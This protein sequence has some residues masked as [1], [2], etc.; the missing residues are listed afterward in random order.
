MRIKLLVLL[1]FS[2]S[3]IC[4]S[5]TV[6][7]VNKVELPQTFYQSGGAPYV[8]NQKYGRVIFGSAYLSEKWMPGSIL[9][10]NGTRYDS[11]RLRLDLLS[12]EVQYLDPLGDSLK[13][14][15]AIAE[16]WLTDSRDNKRF[17]FYNGA[18][19]VIPALSQKRWC[20][21]LSDGEIM[22][23][24]EHNKEMNEQS[25]YGNASKEFSIDE[26]PRYFLYTNGQLRTIK[27]LGDIPELLNDK[28]AELKNFIKSNGLN[29]KNDADYSRLIHYY[30]EVKG[31]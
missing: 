10:T 28:S 20:Q 1:S 27:K 15:A 6:V 23:L 31:K 3:I 16:L 21:L 26:N 17:H 4:N 13:V 19:K 9:L 14:K 12:G 30:Y 8:P 2:C 18:S 5:Q 7:D 11:L 29:G 25:G 22:V 24:K